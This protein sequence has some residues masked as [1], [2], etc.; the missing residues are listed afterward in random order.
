MPYTS[1][2]MVRTTPVKVGSPA[3]SG[4]ISGRRQAVSQ[5]VPTNR[6]QEARDPPRLIDPARRLVQYG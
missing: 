3:D 4:A 1:N 2:R 5:P 6:R